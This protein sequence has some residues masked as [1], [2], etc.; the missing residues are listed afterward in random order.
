M[1]F[2]GYNLSDLDVPY[3]GLVIDF[4]PLLRTALGNVWIYVWF[5]SLYLL[6]PL[7]VS[8]FSITKEESEY[9][10]ITHL[11]YRTLKIQQSLASHF[12]P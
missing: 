6:F 3:T 9:S 4:S 8:L 11:Y 12:F 1:V 10:I 2:Q 5:Y 7:R